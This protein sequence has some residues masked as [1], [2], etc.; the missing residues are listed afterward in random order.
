MKKEHIIKEKIGC[1]KSKALAYG[2]RGEN[3]T[4]ECGRIHLLNV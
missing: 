1:M 4:L 2:K 3:I